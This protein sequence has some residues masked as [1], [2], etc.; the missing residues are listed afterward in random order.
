M[1]RSVTICITALTISA[2]LTACG[3]SGTSSGGPP[4]IV[5]RISKLARLIQIRCRLTPITRGGRL[6]KLPQEGR[7]KLK[8]TLSMIAAVVLWLAFLYTVFVAVTV[9]LIPNV[10]AS[11]IDTQLAFLIVIDLA[12]LQFLAWLYKELPDKPSSRFFSWM[13]TV[14]LLN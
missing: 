14:S 8:R 3:G 7:C 4:K 12:I 2:G 9:H 13:E 6:F 10:T 5:D 11:E 1:N